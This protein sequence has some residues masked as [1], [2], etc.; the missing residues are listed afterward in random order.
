MTILYYYNDIDSEVLTAVD[1]ESS[2]TDDFQI[3]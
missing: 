2:K 1:Y 3:D